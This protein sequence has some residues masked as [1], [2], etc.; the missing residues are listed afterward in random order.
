M[1]LFMQP[2]TT[3]ESGGALLITTRSGAT[4]AAT[5]SPEMAHYAPRGFDTSS[6]FYSPRYDGTQESLL[7]DFRTTIHWEPNLI[8]TETGKAGFDFFNRSEEHTSE[9][10]SLMRISYA[11]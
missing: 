6:E 5:Y 9:L 2:T 1:S 11:V 3:G 10:Q 7:T 8:T 4:R